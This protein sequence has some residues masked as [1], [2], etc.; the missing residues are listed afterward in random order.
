M[1]CGHIRDPATISDDEPHLH[2]LPS[3][4]ILCWR[5]QCP[6][7]VWICTSLRCRCVAHLCPSGGS[8]CLP[9]E[10]A[11]SCTQVTAGFYSTPQSANASLRTGQAMC[12]PGFACAGGIACL[13]CAVW[14]SPPRQAPELHVWPSPHFS[15]KAGGS[16]AMHALRVSP[17]PTPLHAA[18]RVTLYRAVCDQELHH[19]RRHPLCRSVPMFSCVRPCEALQTRLRRSSRCWVTPRSPWSTGAMCTRNPGSTLSTA[20]MAR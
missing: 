16:C 2:T 11:A 8:C 3:R 4:E 7:A 14:C 9:L 20:T 18:A 10:G 12:E 6:C 1:Q 17:V 19:N 13:W 15:V 5:Q